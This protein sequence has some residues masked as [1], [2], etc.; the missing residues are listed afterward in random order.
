MR[1]T[2]FDYKHEFTQ[3]F[4]FSKKKTSFRASKLLH[5]SRTKKNTKNSKCVVIKETEKLKETVVGVQ[6]K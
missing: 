4:L 3:D 6:V 5:N 2:N 1:T